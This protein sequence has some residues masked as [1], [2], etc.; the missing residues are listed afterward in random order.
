M[1]VDRLI[2]FYEELTP[3]SLARF[4]EFYHPEAY[5]KDPFN[6]VRGVTAIRRIFEHMF[7]QTDS[8]KFVVN[9]KLSEGEVALLIWQFSCGVRTW[10]RP[11]TLVLRGASHVKFGVDGR[12]VYHRDYWDAAEELYM[13]LPL[14]GGV[15]RFLRKRFAV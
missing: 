10:G 5:F 13:Q 1:E 7:R 14:L 2:A 15:M 12:V 11:R 4:P 8:P 3:E 6:E 9:E